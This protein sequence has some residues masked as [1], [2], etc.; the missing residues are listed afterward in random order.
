MKVLLKD[1]NTKKWISKNS[2]HV[3]GS[4]FYNEQLLRN[5]ELFDLFDSIESGKKLSKLLDELDGSFAVIFNRQNFKALAVDRWA[6]IPLVFKQRGTEVECIGNE[7]ELPLQAVEPSINHFNLLASAPGKK[8]LFQKW[9]AL[10]AGEFMYSSD[11]GKWSCVR[12]YAHK[13]KGKNNFSNEECLRSLQSARN[14]LMAYLGERRAVI[15]LSGGLDS[16]LIL[17]ELVKAKCSRI[18]CFTYGEGS[19]NEALKAKSV[20]D[21]LKV[22]WEF[23][24]YNRA[25]LNSISSQ[26]WKEYDQTAHFGVSLPYDQDFFAIKYLKEQSLIDT[27]E[28]V[29]LPGYLGDHLGGSFHVFNNNQPNKQEVIQALCDKFVIE[30][31][32]KNISDLLLSE[33]EQ[34]GNDL[35][36]TYQDWLSIHR[37]SRF[38]NGGWRAFDFFCFD[39]YTF[40]TNNKWMEFWYG[41]EWTERLLQ[42]KYIE[43]L[44][45]HIFKPLNISFEEDKPR[46]MSAYKSKA[47]KALPGTALNFL[48]K[49]RLDNAPY[50]EILLEIL[51]EQKL[52]DRKSAKNNFNVVHS[53]ILVDKIF[54]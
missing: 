1:F 36:S 54:E 16:R 45:E 9:F 43:F 4:A 5:G 18:L 30:S 32:P 24:P 29:V 11:S 23:V 13:I 52:L 26:E 14:N 7:F 40:A 34:E 35:L 51:I 50:E 44:N 6:S 21:E 10:Q 48:K 12:Y 20:C 49:R 53:K 28:D 3:I 37:H 19:S 39:S 33:F 22:S 27:R 41:L 15:P 31:L 17:A 42:K 46:K 38:I 25:V 8:T 47:K 2:L